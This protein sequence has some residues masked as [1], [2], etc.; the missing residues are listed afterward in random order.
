MDI[1]FVDKELILNTISK[2]QKKL[3]EEVSTDVTSHLNEST[4]FVC[5]LAMPTNDY[6]PVNKGD[7][8]DISQNKGKMIG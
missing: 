1:V 6:W 5:L 8:S 4:C 2:F 3:S 7:L